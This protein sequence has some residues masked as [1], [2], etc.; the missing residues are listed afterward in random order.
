MTWHIH[1]K[2]QVQGVGFRPFVYQLA[3]RHVLNGWVNNTSDGV[4]IE[5][6]ANQAAAE[7]FLDQISASAPRLAQITEL[8]MGK[9]DDREYASFD[10][11]HSRAQTEVNL[12][13]SPDF[14]L[15]DQC[16][17]ELYDADSRRYN[18]AFTSC[19]HCGPRYSII[20][21]L[22]YDRPFTSMAE[23]PLCPSC[24]QEYHDPQ[25]RRY[26]A[27]TNSCC[28]CRIALQLLDSEGNAIAI[29]QEEIVKQVADL[30]QAGKIIAIKGIGGYLLTC[31]ARNAQA[32]ASLRQRKQRAKKPFALLFP[33]IEQARDYVEV[34]S[35][36]AA[37]L[38]SAAAPIV[39]AR[40]RS[41]AEQKLAIGEIA[42]GLK[43]LGVM[44]PYTPL[45]ELLAHQFGHPLVATSANISNA[46]IV[47]DEATDLALLSGLADFILANER[48]IL[49]PQDDSVVTVSPQA[50]QAII[51][52]RSRGYAPSFILPE[53]NWS[54]PETLATGAM[55]KSTFAVLHKNN[56]YLSQ[57]LGD[58]QHF[59]TQQ[60][61]RHCF[62]HLK[63]LLN[64]TPQ[65]MLADLHPDYP[66]T[67]LGQDWS[68][69]QRIPIRY[70][71]HHEA[72][73]GAILG[74]HQLIH[75]PEP[76]LGVIW[77]GTGLGT[78]G[79]I[80]G[81]EFFRYR[82][83]QFQRCQH[84]AY[85]KWLAADKMAREPRIAAL[86]IGADSPDALNMLRHRFTDQEWK[87]YHN[88]LNKPSGLE[89]SSV[90]RLF[91][92]AAALIL[93]INRQDY[94]GE[95][96]ML[97]QQLAEDYLLPQGLEQINAYPIR[98]NSDAPLPTQQL[99]QALAQDLSAGT[100]PSEVA[101]KFHLTL[102]MLIKT[103]AEQ[104]ATRKVAFSGGVFQNSLLV[105]LLHH[106]MGDQFSLYFHQQLSPN[107]ENISFGQLVCA[108]IQQ[109]HSFLHSKT[110]EHVLSNSG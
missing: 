75:D 23:F 104:E 54:I 101:A 76:I 34:S 100:P 102:V 30:W 106:Y 31:D 85:F 32:V 26:F 94:E 87:L 14:A 52:R 107:D 3:Q 97:L 70:I 74:E 16:R 81:G 110:K 18:Y 28:T 105:D 78:D 44:L 49:L 63:G 24:T 15:C 93:G 20:K 61:Y 11:I 84:F 96:A 40:L 12:L 27:Q 56:L 37:L 90:G 13:L 57:Y 7:A 103:V 25:D 65:L 21:D 45:Y 88:R 22:P 1:I 6:N 67:R 68:E 51:I 92:A 82:N 39:L 99:I 108:E 5:F 17:K 80:W 66:S 77:D 86:A 2:G 55:L 10:I 41:S 83:Y 50:N 9:T 33:G 72:H 62:A 89:S 71:Q 42:P 60:S 98:V 36:E 53:M 43:K 35:E 38:Q 46:P 73:F 59:D 69:Q 4:H 79:Q 29:S 8:A 48:E 64:A 47:F 58:L 95:A 91:D 109:Q 19:T